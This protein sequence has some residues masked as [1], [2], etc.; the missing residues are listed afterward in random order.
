MRRLRVEAQHVA[1]RNVIGNR[2]KIVFH[3]LI[4]RKLE[5]LPTRQPRDR[6]GN[7]PLQPVDRGNYRHLGECQ[8]RR[9][10]AEAV[11]RL[12]P[13]VARPIRVGVR[14][15]AHAAVDR[16]GVMLLKA[17]QSRRPAARLCGKLP[18]CIMRRF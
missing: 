2:Q 14:V 8:G 11:I 18:R 9:E 10:L 7:I 1:V 13:S 12:F 17:Q 16:V 4:V 3:S 15:F 6:F 5:I